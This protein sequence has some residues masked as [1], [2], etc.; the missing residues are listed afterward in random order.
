MR[1]NE[2]YLNLL[3]TSLGACINAIVAKWPLVKPRRPERAAG[4][5]SDLREEQAIIFRG[6]CISFEECAIA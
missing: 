3:G 6:P 4:Q 5:K 1:L 2:A